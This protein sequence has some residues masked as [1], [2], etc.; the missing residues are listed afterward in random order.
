[1]TNITCGVRM[2]AT[3]VRRAFS[4][5]TTGGAFGAFASPEIFKIVHG[6]FDSSRNFPRIKKKFY[7]LI[8]FRNLIRIFLCPTGKLSPYKIYLETYCLIENFVNDWYLT[9]NVLELQAW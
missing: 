4:R 6:N 7:I 2:D 3:N 9:T 1:M 8:I 5:R